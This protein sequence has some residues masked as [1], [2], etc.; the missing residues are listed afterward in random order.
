MVLKICIFV[1]KKKINGWVCVCVYIY[2][3]NVWILFFLISY[4]II[5]IKCGKESSS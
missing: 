3:L 1:S 2:I 5:Y 4:E